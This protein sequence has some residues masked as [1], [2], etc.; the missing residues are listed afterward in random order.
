MKNRKKKPDWFEF[1][2]YIALRYRKT[3]MGRTRALPMG[4]A[5]ARA[6]SDDRPIPTP[7]FYGWPLSS[8]PLCGRNPYREYQWGIPIRNTYMFN[9]VM[10]NIKHII[11]RYYY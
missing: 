9:V 7:P 6:N 10:N 8:W 4:K 3:S 11:Y 5:R 2:N 1:G